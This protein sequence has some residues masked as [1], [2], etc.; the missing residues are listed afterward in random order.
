MENLRQTGKVF[1]RSWTAFV[2]QAGIWIVLLTIALTAI[3][4]NYTVNNL[5]MNT[6]T[7]DMLSP[8]LNWRQLDLEYERHFPQFTDNILVVVEADTPDQAL[9]AADLFY[10]QL[11]DETTLFKSVYYPNAL[12]IFKESALLFLDVDELQDLADNLAEIQPFLSRL[13]DDQTLRGFFSMLSEALDAI[14]D[15]EKIDIAPM[16]NQINLTI[17]ATLQKKSTPYVL[18]QSHAW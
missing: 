2:E 16:L 12:S 18:A 11:L 10:R 13:T 1:L 4:F 7:K 15:G 9:D 5:G 14:Q 17:D 8:E 3:A 6:D